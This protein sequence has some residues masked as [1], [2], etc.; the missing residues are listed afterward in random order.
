VTH[1]L[2]TPLSLIRLY[3]ETLTLGRAEVQADQEKCGAVILSECD[4]LTSMVEKI[5]DFSHMDRGRFTYRPR[6]TRVGGVVRE[7]VEA[8]RPQ[9]ER[10]SVEI[11]WD[12]DG[13]PEVYLDEEGFRRCLFNLMDNAVKFGGGEVEIFLGEEGEEV[14]LEVRDRGPG[15]PP[16]ERDKVLQPFYRGEGAGEKRGS[17]L[18]LSLVQHFVEY[19]DGVI[20]ILDRTGGGTV[21][22]IAFPKAPPGKD[23]NPRR[24]VET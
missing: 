19:H 11:H 12:M 14:T 1:D 8:F 23:P 6:R 24:E 21:F 5:L 10:Q 20:Q 18:G 15:I 7:A 3:A 4:R 17:G 13:D 16:G 2:K 9:A 22:R